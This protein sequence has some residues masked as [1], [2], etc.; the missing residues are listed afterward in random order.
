MK[1]REFWDEIEMIHPEAAIMIL[2]LREY[3]RK[4]NDV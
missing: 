2:E 3:R 4:I 1:E